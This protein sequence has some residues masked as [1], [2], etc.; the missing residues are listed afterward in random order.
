[1]AIVSKSVRIDEDLWHKAR[2]KAMAERKTMQDLIAE[3]LKQ[4]LKKGRR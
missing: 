2:V 4:Y 1:M 3:L